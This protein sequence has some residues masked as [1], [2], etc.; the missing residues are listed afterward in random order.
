MQPVLVPGVR[1]AA[2]HPVPERRRVRI[3]RGAQVEPVDPV[4]L[5][6]QRAEVQ[7]HTTTVEAEQRLAER[8]RHGHDD[9][10]G[11]AQPQR[12]IAVDDFRVERRSRRREARDARGEVRRHG[13]RLADVGRRDLR[14]RRRREPRDCRH[15]REPHV[16]DRPPRAAS[17]PTETSSASAPSASA[18]IVSVEVPPPPMDESASIVGAGASDDSGPVQSTT[19]PSE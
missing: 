9:R 5:R 11:H 17:E 3:R 10:P 19:D 12:L 15:E 7:P 2:R 6:R 4:G 1:V 8:A 16:S 14:H 18:T 13:Q